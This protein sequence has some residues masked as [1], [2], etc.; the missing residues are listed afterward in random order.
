[1]EHNAVPIGVAIC[2]FIALIA[3]SLMLGLPAFFYFGALGAAKITLP[4]HRFRHNVVRALWL[5][6]GIDLACAV[7]WF[8]A[9]SGSMGASWNE[10]CGQAPS[11]F[12][13]AGQVTSER[14]LIIH[15]VLIVAF[16]GALTLR[17]DRVRMPVL[18]FCAFESSSALAWTNQAIEANDT[19]GLIYFF[20]DLIHRTV[21]GLWLGSIVGLLLFLMATRTASLD[22]SDAV[23]HLLP[24][25]F[26]PFSAFCLAIL[27]ASGLGAMTLSVGDIPHLIGTDYGRLIIAKVCLLAVLL[28][29]VAAY[30][31]WRPSGEICSDTPRKDRLFRLRRFCII[32]IA[33]SSSAVA[34]SA[35]LST[36]HPALHQEPI[37]PLPI[38]LESGVLG[39]P[40]VSGEVWK[41]GIL[42]V[43]G[44]GLLV[45]SIARRRMRLLT[46]S[47]GLTLMFVFVPAMGQLM[48]V[49]AYPTTFQDPPS[50]YDTASIY[51]GWQAYRDNC[52]SCH[53]KDF[54]GSGDASATLA[55]RPADLTASHILAHPPGDL[56]WW[57]SNG[58]PTAGM[59]G[60]SANLSEAE[61]WDLVKFVRTLPDSGLGGTVGS[62]GTQAPDFTFSLG[63]GQ[64]ERLSE[65]VAKGPL[66][67]AVLDNAPSN[68]LQQLAEAKE[69][70]ETAGIGLLAIT[71]ASEASSRDF[72]FVG[73]VDPSVTFVYAALS[74]PA[75]PSGSEFLIDSAGF[76]RAVWRQDRTPNWTARDIPRRLISDL[77]LQPKNKIDAFHSH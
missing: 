29:F 36:M 55:V 54:K 9:S 58:I 21:S 77:M 23:E 27:L 33:V 64:Q 26:L 75:L 72:S 62:H 13:M 48:S 37:W 40:A 32:G 74:G 65:R 56:F 69:N 50:P 10:L 4:M 45:L 38:R 25:R 34:M 47:I 16:I 5:A 66:V 22:D 24:R 59:P 57:I 52:A 60:F 1:M 31:A 8:V 17:D 41:A 61:R 28:G 35:A 11:L 2:R 46:G 42:S 67:I 30:R 49:P 43:V 44:I 14:A 39:E 3:G 6:S 63:S 53:G 70:L 18:I 19:P 51:R 76:V 68:R 20:V 12:L 71:T 7:A 15:L 73:T